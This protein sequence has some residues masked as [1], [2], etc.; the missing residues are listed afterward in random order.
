MEGTRRNGFYAAAETLLRIQSEGTGHNSS[1]QEMA[2]SGSGEAAHP[3]PSTSEEKTTLYDQISPH[4]SPHHLEYLRQI[5]RTHFAE[6]LSS[7]FN[8][9]SE[10]PNPLLRPEAPSNPEYPHNLT[11]NQ[12]ALL[13]TLCSNPP[14]FL[15]LLQVA[16]VRSMTES[17]FDGKKPISEAQILLRFFA[18]MSRFF[19]LSQVRSP[20]TQFSQEQTTLPADRVLQALLPSYA[21]EN[22]LQK[23]ELDRA[24]AVI[25]TLFLVI[26]AKELIN[27]RSRA[28]D[29][30]QQTILEIIDNQL[31]LF[32]PNS[33]SQN[34]AE[35]ERNLARMADELLW[36]I[37]AKVGAINPNAPETE[38]Q[39]HEHLVM[40]LIDRTD[41][42]FTLLRLFRG[43]RLGK[44]GEG[45]GE[46][47]N[48]SDWLR[49]QWEAG[50]K[51]VLMYLLA[52]VE[53]NFAERIAE[54]P[55]HSELFY[56]LVRSAICTEPYALS[57]YDDFREAVFETEQPSEQ[58]YMLIIPS[59][60]HLF[61]I[62]LKVFRKLLPFEQGDRIQ[63]VLRVSVLVRG[64]ECTTTTFPSE[65][66]PFLS[67]RVAGALKPLREGD[68]TAQPREFASVVNFLHALLEQAHELCNQQSDIQD[69]RLVDIDPV[70]P[71]F[72]GDT[73][74]QPAP[75]ESLKGGALCFGSVTIEITFTNCKKETMEVQIFADSE[76]KT[77]TQHHADKVSDDVSYKLRSLAQ[78]IALLFP[79]GLG[80]RLSS[81]TSDQEQ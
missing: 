63:D 54:A 24:R 31:S 71:E 38:A 21:G 12:Q 65:L 51:I 64:G 42:F 76:G 46:K 45:E 15:D 77:A 53:E 25:T 16:E 47:F 56:D 43:E 58:C 28:T 29:T 6:V 17:G 20:V 41:D 22:T 49:L 75:G 34:L 32:P 26:P 37:A 35:L 80:Y 60:K 72:A 61:S 27:T 8:Q 7:H 62:L 79:E 14:A 55:S 74:Q 5:I 33:S 4:L 59:N 70:C 2:V 18:G 9:K 1:L 48:A 10:Q 3:H 69:I 57:P 78:I 67:K 19:Q 23:T 68:S 39:Q 81:P 40:E 52:R 30:P 44:L 50:R 36:Y 66:E 73:E 11:P 13:Q